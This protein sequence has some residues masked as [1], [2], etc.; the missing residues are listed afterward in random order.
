MKFMVAFDRLILCHYFRLENFLVNWIST[1][2]KKNPSL[3]LFPVFKDL[4][5]LRNNINFQA[6]SSADQ[7]DIQFQIPSLE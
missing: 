3:K 1:C 7:T 5:F 4:S 6:N 2:L